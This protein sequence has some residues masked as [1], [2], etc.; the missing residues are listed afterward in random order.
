MKKILLG[1]VIAVVVA[2]GGAAVFLTLKTPAQR[3]A[4]DLKVEATPERL[5]RGRYLVEHVSA[6]LHCH[7]PGDETRWGIP[8]K[9]ELRGA[10]GM[11]LTEAVGFAGIVCAKNITQHPE[12]G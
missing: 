3:P 8:F 9:P 7:S 12:H 1:I 5:E 4:P 11:C 6:C 2:A 10:G